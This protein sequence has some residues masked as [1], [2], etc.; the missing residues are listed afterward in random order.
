MVIIMFKRRRVLAFFI[1]VL[2]VSFVTILLASN[3]KI[4]KYYYET[5]D[6][7]KAL[8]EK[9]KS[10]TIDYGDTEHAID[11]MFNQ[12]GQ[13]LYDSTKVQVYAYTIFLIV[14]TL[15]FAVFAF[16]NDGK[17]L[18][19]ALCRIKIVKKNDKK[20]NIFNLAMRSLFM[21]SSLIYISPL[22]AI[23]SIIIPR[24]LDVRSAFLPLVYTSSLLLMFE[25][26]LFI[27]FLV[28]KNNMTI[29]DYLSN[30]K[31]IDTKK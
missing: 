13:E 27:V 19:C 21:G 1:D 4:N 14:N 24:V 5:E 11:N 6:Y 15:Y 29:Q 22:I 20:P 8:M 12:I 2:L 9:Q 25:I 26:A 10:L 3:P 23:T 17:T 30:T 18:G 31:I 28:N 16:F 7:N